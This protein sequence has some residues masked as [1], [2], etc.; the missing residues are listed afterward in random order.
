MKTKECDIRYDQIHRVRKLFVCENE[1]IIR[2][3]FEAIKLHF[4][5]ISNLINSMSALRIK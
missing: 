4:H 3:W 2:V 5:I 1:K